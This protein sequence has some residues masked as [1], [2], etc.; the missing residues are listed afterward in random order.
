MILVTRGPCL[1]K[2][3]VCSICTSSI[4]VGEESDDNASTCS[5]ASTIACEADVELAAARRSVRCANLC[6]CVCVCVCRCVRERVRERVHT[7]VRMLMRCT[8]VRARIDMCA[9]V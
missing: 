3:D 2:C 7:H 8:S 4:P 1:C 6:V 9:C 5:C